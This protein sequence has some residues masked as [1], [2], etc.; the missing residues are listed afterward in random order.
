MA[1]RHLISENKYYKHEINRSILNLQ[2][3][4]KR[5][6]FA[7]LC[8]FFLDQNSY[9]FTHCKKIVKWSTQTKMYNCFFESTFRLDEFLTPLRSILKKLQNMYLIMLQ[10]CLHAKSHE[11]N[12]EYLLRYLRTD[13]KH[14]TLFFYYSFRSCILLNAVLFRLCNDISLHPIIPNS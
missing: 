7:T 10:N 14:S 3:F 6:T 2:N 9:Y 8:I 5:S 4:T 1:G 13:R 11:R 12:F